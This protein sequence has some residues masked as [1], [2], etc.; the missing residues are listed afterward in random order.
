MSLFF[1]RKST[2]PGPRT[3]PVNTGSVLTLLDTHEAPAPVAPGAAVALRSTV[4]PLANTLA[5]GPH[6][7]ALAE[8][9]ATNVSYE[10]CLN[11]RLGLSATLAAQVAVLAVDAA[12]THAALLLTRGVGPDLLGSLLAQMAQHK[13]NLVPKDQVQAWWCAPALVAAVVGGEITGDASRRTR[14]L[15]SDTAKSGHWQIFKSVIEWAYTED[16]QDIDFVV[17]LHELESYVRFKVHSRWVAPERWRMPTEQMTKV[18]SVAWQQSQGGASSELQF[19]LDQQAVIGLSL[20]HDVRLRLRWNTMPN[21]RGATITLRLQR[22]GAQRLVKTLDEAGYLPTQIEILERVVTGKGGLTTLCGT[23]GSGKT[24]TLAI[25]MELMYSRRP[26]IKGISFEDPVEIETWMD[27]RT[28]TRDLYAKDDEA[29]RTAVV[30]L[31][32]SAL[33]VFLLGEVRD[34]DAGRTLRA[35]LDSGHSCFTTTHAAD[36]LT[37]IISKYT[38]AQCGIPAS[39]L[40]TPGMLKLNVYQ[41]LLLKNCAHC[42]LTHEQ[43]RATLITD[44]QRSAFAKLLDDIELVCPGVQRETLRFHNPLGCEHCRRDGLDSLRGFA[45]R[46]VIAEMVEPDERMCE[47]ILKENMPEL[48]RYWR[49]L[50]DGNIASPHFEGKTAMEVAMHKAS[51]GLIDPYEIEKEFDAFATMAAK[52]KTQQRL[53]PRSNIAWARSGLGVSPAAPQAAMDRSAT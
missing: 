10:M 7:L 53:A 51:L 36:C 13:V 3:S 39:L 21:D 2:P 46:T 9:L 37:G 40:A 31:F 26:D 1:K 25:L 45:G 49:G 14:A 42:S 41:S 47:L 48:R 5:F 20:N 8:D 23:V 32:R 15:A 16:A 44:A 33:D 43:H 29:F 50:S 35:V 38:S 17:Q 12:G 19:K 27:Q 34:V 4:H 24:V 52:A 28:I 11:E 22:L 6:D 18:L 30:S